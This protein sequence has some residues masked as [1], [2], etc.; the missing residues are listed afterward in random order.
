[1]DP[2][3]LSSCSRGMVES[4]KEGDPEGV[5]LMETWVFIN[6]HVWTEDR[7]A[8]FLSGIEKTEDAILLDLMSDLV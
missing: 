4:I 7:V 2:D 8:A 3:Y 1:M 5:W 6:F